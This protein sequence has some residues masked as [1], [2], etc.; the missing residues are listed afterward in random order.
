MNQT[1]KYDSRF[2]NPSKETLE[3]LLLSRMEVENLQRRTIKCPICSFTASI[4]YGDCTG[5]TNIKCQKCKFEGPINLAF[6]RRMKNEYYRS[7]GYSYGLRQ[8]R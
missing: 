4:T 1:I 3:K 7:H 8:C 5:H 6:F 2:G